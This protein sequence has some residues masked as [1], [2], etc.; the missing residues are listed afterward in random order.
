M[1][2]ILLGISRP[3]ML[4]FVLAGMLAV[5]LSRTSGGR[6]GYG[7]LIKSAHAIAEA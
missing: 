2:E 1:S 6:L 7:K 3:A 5:G 4:A